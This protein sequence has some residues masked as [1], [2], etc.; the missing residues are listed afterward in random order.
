MIAWFVELSKFGL[1]FDPWGP[2]PIKAQCLADFIAEN[3]TKLSNN[4]RGNWWMLCVNGACN[5]KGSR[6]GITF[7]GPRD[8]SLEQSLRLDF[9]TSNNQAG[10]EALIPGLKLAKEVGVKKIGCRSDSKFVIGQV[11]GDFQ[12][13]DTHMQ[14]YYHLMM[15]WLSWFDKYKI[16]HIFKE[17]NDK[18]YVL[19]KLASFKKLG[20]H[21]TFIQE[22]LVTPS[23]QVKLVV[24]FG[25]TRYRIIWWMISY[26]Q[27]KLRQRK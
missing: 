20:Q 11:N 27:M 13:K 10:Y 1:K 9:K 8:V 22:T 15:R 24:T 7:E 14:M 2:R 18:S 21:R 23:L 25:W 17:N 19:S 26:L 5:P 3:P 12:V 16:K 4:D 6:V